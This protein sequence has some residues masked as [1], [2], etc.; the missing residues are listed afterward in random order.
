VLVA[1]VVL[2]MGLLA[3]LTVFSLATRATGASTNDTLLPMLA[4]QKL[5]E[6]RGLPRDELIAETSE[7]DFG[8]DYPGYTWELT[9]S[10]PD[11]LHVVRVEL[12]IQA[13]EMGRKRD[14]KFAT[15]IF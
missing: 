15:D 12:T 2:A 6:V 9:I 4:A 5:A 8:E 1:T 14:V 11:D 13:M 3:A 7:G 10:P